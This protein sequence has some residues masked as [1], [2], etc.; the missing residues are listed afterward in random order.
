MANRQIAKAGDYFR[1]EGAQVR[2]SRASRNTEKPWVD[3]D[4]TADNG[5]MWSK[6]MPTGIPS[7]WDPIDA[8]GNPRLPRTEVTDA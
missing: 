7:S 8:A 2:V 3:I 1:V 4:V 6:R 5:W